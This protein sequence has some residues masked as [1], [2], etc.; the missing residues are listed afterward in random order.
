MGGMDTLLLFMWLRV[1][2]GLVQGT[3]TAAL[4]VSRGLV[5]ALTEECGEL[6]A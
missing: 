3:P 2:S 4:H 5:V 1:L 6:W